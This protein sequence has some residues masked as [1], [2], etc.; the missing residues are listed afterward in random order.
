MSRSP[1]RSAFCFPTFFLFSSIHCLLTC[2]RDDLQSISI[3]FI[4]LHVT[5]AIW[6]DDLTSSSD[7]Y[8]I[9]IQLVQ[10]LL[11]HFTSRPLCL[12]STFQSHLLSSYC[13]AIAS[14]QKS[15]YQGVIKTT[16]SFFWSFNLLQYKRTASHSI[17][18]AKKYQL[19]VKSLRNDQFKSR[20]PKRKSSISHKSTTHQV[21]PPFKLSLLASNKIVS[22]L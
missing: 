7:L 8:P 6:L 19:H 14:F 17:S 2:G 20:L 15:C 21:Y 5:H 13:S 9:D 11:I 10:S 4:L 12:N 18:M 22:R 1:S 16:F 3:S